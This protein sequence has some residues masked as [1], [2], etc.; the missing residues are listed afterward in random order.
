MAAKRP[1]VREN[2][3]NLL[4][5]TTLYPSLNWM[6][7]HG[8]TSRLR[9]IHKELR[10][11]GLLGSCIKN[12]VNPQWIRKGID[13]EG[14]YYTTEPIFSGYLFMELITVNNPKWPDIEE[15][16]GIN[17]ILT[18]SIKDRWTKQWSYL[19]YLLSVDEV[20]HVMRLTSLTMSFEKKKLQSLLGQIVGIIT[21]PF[22]KLR[23]I[24][25]E[26]GTKTIKVELAVLH[27]ILPV[28]ISRTCVKLAIDLYDEELL[29]EGV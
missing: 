15:I 3:H 8:Y 5:I 10:K 20:A 27:K 14:E 24:V 22:K 1:K 19:P 21:G 25:V 18:R 9:E 29:L 17:K 4:P 13:D 2:P 7:A 11:T 6:V 12:V 16:E 23:G 26:D 28:R